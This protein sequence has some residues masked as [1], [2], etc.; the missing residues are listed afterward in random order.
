MMDLLGAVGLRRR[1]DEVLCEATLSVLAGVDKVRV[2]EGQLDSTAVDG[3]DSLHTEHEGVVLVTDLV[4]PAAESATGQDV[5]GLELGEDLL[6]D[7]LTLKGRSG[8]T[9]VESTVVGGDDLVLGL[10]HL[11][12]DE[13]LDAVLEEVL[14]ING[15][16]GRLGNLQH[17]G[18]V[19]TLLSLR[20]GSLLTV[21]EVESGELGVLLR[22]VVGGVVGEDGG[23]VE[24]AV[25]LGEVQPALVTDA[26]RA[27][28]SDTDT[29]NVGS[30]VVELLGEADELLVTH[31]LGEVV[32]GH[33]VDELVVADGAAVGEVGNLLLGIDLGDCTLLTESLLL[34]GDGLSDGDPDTT[35]TITGRESESSVGAPVTSNLVE[36]D[37]L[38]NELSIRSGDTL[39]EPLALHLSHEDVGNTLTHHAH[40]PLVEVLGLGVGDPALESGVDDTLDTLDLVLLGKHGDVVLERVR[41]PEALVANVGDS[42][43][44]VPVI[45]L[46][47][48]LV[49][50]VVEV[51]VV[52]K[53]NVATDIVQLEE[54]SGQL[55]FCRR[56][57][58][59]TYETLGGDVSA[60]KTTSLVRRVDNQP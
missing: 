57:A 21:G 32:N 55:L 23:A 50:A 15:L 5:H 54:S 26:L 17:D 24:G 11:S 8:V 36:D 59:T 6:E 16:H 7:S 58:A 28:T 31:L 4:S 14:N 60:G 43:V 48:S 19:R 18:P 13:T 34:L 1:Q 3:I 46:G 53:D 56:M 51:L 37:V 9:V 30:R 45:I 47:E 20:R 33:G 38:G 12:V 39:T 2:V 40:N 22:L 29:N 42:L 52:R 44:S 27:L 35:G 25:V 49:D 41:D 10:D